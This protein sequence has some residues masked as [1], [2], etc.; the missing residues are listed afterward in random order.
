MRKNWFRKYD[1][2]NVPTSLSYKNEYFYATNIGA[3]LTIF[4]FII[5]ISLITY[6]I[7]LLYEKS[8]FTLISN[9]YTDLFQPIDFSETPFLFQLINGNGKYLDLDE[10]LYDLVA[11][12]MEQKIQTYENGTRK[13]KISNTRI[14]F[15]KCDKIYSNET[16]YSE[17][18]LSRYIC[19]KPGQNLSAFGLLG[20]LNKPYR[21]IRIYINKCSGDNCYD[22]SVIEKQFHNAKFFVNYLSLS[23]NMFNFKGE[24]IKYQIFT[25]FCSLSSNILKKVVFTFDSGRFYLHNNIFFANKKISFNYLL[26]NDY[27]LDVDL[28]P[29][30][31]LSSN[32][33]TIAYISFHYG[34]NIIETRKQVQTI[35]Q[36]LS[37]VGNIFNIIL[38]LFKVINSYYSNKILFF[39]IFNTVFFAKEKMNFNIKG[40]IYNHTQLN[41]INS[42][43]HKKNLD[44]SDQ[45]YFNN[46]DKNNDK[47]NN[48]MK[49]LS[50][51]NKMIMQTG[52]NPVLRRKS[53]TYVENKGIFAKT[54]LMYYY[55]LPLW[56]LRRS[57]TFNNLY[58][59]KDRICGYFSIEKINELIQFKENMEKNTAKSKLNNTE[60]IKY[61]CNNENLCLNDGKKKN[62]QIIK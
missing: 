23:S 19:F 15:E 12:N 48:S 61:N 3:S 35:F 51:S 55:I 38:T 6:E 5:I 26:G 18:N 33:Y 57:K 47:N 31:T 60:L 53:K 62:V 14:E 36:S 9:Q 20:D 27:T 10:K 34:G 42:L 43:N 22:N 7:I 58:S 40:N 25:K 56:V 1:F 39:D 28:D 13:R 59:I 4:F 37:L 49:Q 46:N 44:L 17:L 50:N 2:L 8:S 41:K 32:E 24:D 29:T 54:S 52:K 16:E 11:Y 45:M 30:S 21:G